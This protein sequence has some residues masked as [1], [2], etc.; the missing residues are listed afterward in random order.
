MRELIAK[1]YTNALLKSMDTNEIKLT[2][3]A[4]D[5]ASSCFKIKKLSTILESP[6]VSN[7]KKEELILSLFENPSKKLINLIK[8]LSENGRL[9]IVPDIKDELEYQLSL[10]ENS[11]QGA[12]EGIFELSNEQLG[13][14]EESFS[15]KFDAKIV[16]KNQ[17]SDFPGI[18][19]SFEDLGVEVSFSLDR[20]K[21][22]MAEHILKA[23]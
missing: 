5:E 16:L 1:K 20:L 12:V 18:R 23:I 8:L 17:K 13:Q 21:A 2:L 7:E 3:K 9:S 4:F 10:Q 15:K 22:Q 14:L 19:I 6:D 11:Y